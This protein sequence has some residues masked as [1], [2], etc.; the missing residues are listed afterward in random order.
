MNTADNEQVLKRNI[1]PVGREAL[2]DLDGNSGWTEKVPRASDQ[3]AKRERRGRG[4]RLVVPGRD[5][6]RAKAWG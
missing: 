3:E 6:L 4:H 2:P 5:A 1:L